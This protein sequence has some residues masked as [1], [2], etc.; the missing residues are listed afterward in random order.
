MLLQMGL[1]WGISYGGMFA[2]K[3][4]ISAV[5]LGKEEFVEALFSAGERLVGSISLEGIHAVQQGSDLTLKMGLGEQM[6]GALLYNL[7]CLF[8]FRERM[9]GGKVLVLCISV[10][11]FC[12]FL[13]YLFRDKEFSPHL[14][15]LFLLLSGVVYLHCL[16]LS[17][18]SYLHYFFTYRAQLTGVTA[19]LYCT[20]R[21]GLKGG[22]RKKRG[23][24]QTRKE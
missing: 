4:G 12:V 2:L 18:H 22:L 16:I 3:W 10:V 7:G 1:I 23:R 20:W 5:I 14:C 19:L 21:F 17:N 24:Q 8:P 6:M 11:L 9:E 15:S 13:I